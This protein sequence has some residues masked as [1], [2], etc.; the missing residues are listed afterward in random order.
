MDMVLCLAFIEMNQLLY[1]CVKALKYAVEDVLLLCN[2]DVS[3]CFSPIINLFFLFCY[4]VTETY[5]NGQIVL[6]G[7]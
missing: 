5:L 1:N 6:H 7:A 3:K 2:G 4:C